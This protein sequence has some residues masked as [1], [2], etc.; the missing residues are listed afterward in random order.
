M[1]THARFM[2]TQGN[3]S[4]SKLVEVRTTLKFSHH[5][6]HLRQGHCC[7]HCIYGSL[8]AS[9]DFLVSTHFPIR[10]LRLLQMLMPFNYQAF[11]RLWSWGIKELR[12]LYLCASAFTRWA[13]SMV[14]K[15]CFLMSKWFFSA[16]NFLFYLI[17]PGFSILHLNN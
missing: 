8:Q 16:F 15:K 12:S 3:R 7:F 4:H 13:I 9:S 6:P 10:V 2:L 14:Q 11:D 5:L 17:S 1:C